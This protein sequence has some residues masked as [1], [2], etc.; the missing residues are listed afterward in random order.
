MPAFQLLGTAGKRN[1]DQNNPHQPEAPSACV[2][3]EGVGGSGMA[4]EM[5]VCVGVRGG[6]GE[7]RG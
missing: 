4:W 2:A 5:C 6:R 1:E 3:N 7:A